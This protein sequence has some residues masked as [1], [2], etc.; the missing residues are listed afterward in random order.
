MFL[1][2]YGFGINPFDIALD[3]KKAF[4]SFDHKQMTNRLI[5]FKDSKG[6]GVFTA[7]PGYGKTFT[8]RC[9]AES[10][11]PQ[12]HRVIYICMSTL[13]AMDF[14]RQLCLELNL[15]TGYSKAKM[16]RTIK[17]HLYNSHRERRLPFM[18]VLDEA[19]HLKT[20]ILQD[21]KMLMNYQYDSMYPFTLILIGEP[22]LNRI[23]DRSTHEALRQ[24]I[25]VHY[26]FQG[27]N[28]DEIETYLQHKF[29]IAGASY[30]EIIGEGVIAAIEAGCK[31]TPRMIDQIM[32]Q[33]LLAG[34][35]EEKPVITSDMILWACD[36]LQL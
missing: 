35:Q 22:D 19:H 11:N 23:L 30:R 7:P 9:F 3:T 12:L 14:Y 31:G 8:M 13:S 1:P 28:S 29:E 32:T 26:D 25:A 10:L 33:A 5:Y 17:E 6:I 4:L 21:F 18:L 16:V 36:S 15:D 20:E 27:L 24:R 34:S 2:F